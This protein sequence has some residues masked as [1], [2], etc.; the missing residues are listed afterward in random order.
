MI[1]RRR[2]DDEGKKSP[3]SR[4]NINTRRKQRWKAWAKDILCQSERWGNKL[5]KFQPQKVFFGDEGLTRCARRKFCG[6]EG[7]IWKLRKRAAAVSR[8][9]NLIRQKKARENCATK[10]KERSHNIT[11]PQ[12]TLIK[13]FPS[14]NC[15]VTSCARLDNNSN[16][17]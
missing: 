16:E 6:S 13:K 4:I 5:R 15:S 11:F 3:R 2:Y 1:P 12:A 14:S 17:C 7:N 8:P 9:K 10:V